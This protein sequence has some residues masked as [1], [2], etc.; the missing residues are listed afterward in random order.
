MTPCSRCEAKCCKYV[1]VEV[2]K[3]TTPH[4][5][6]TMR[7]MLAHRNVNVFIDERKWFLNIPGRCQYLGRDN[8][9]AIYDR[10]PRIC[11]SHTAGDCEV[12]GG[13]DC[14]YMF[15]KPEDLA[16]YMTEKGIKFPGR[17]QREIREAQQKKTIRKKRNPSRK[18]A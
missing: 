8:R 16:R 11:R 18:K 7:W 15:R 1:A 10:R 4:D 13:F 6:D 5:F 9:C 17:W 12:D 3:P 14:E 2:D